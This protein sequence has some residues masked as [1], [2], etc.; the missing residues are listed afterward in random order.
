M[1]LIKKLKDGYNIA[2]I[3]DAGT[4]GISDPGSIMVRNCIKYG[5]NFEIIPGATAVTTALV[6]SGLDTSK[7]IFIGFLPRDVKSKMGILED[8]AERR[9]TLIFYEAPH[10][11]LNTLKQMRTA[12]G[13]RYAAVC[14]EL[15]K[16]HEEILRSTL[17]EI[18]NYYENREIRGEFVIVVKGK[19]EEEFMREKR[20][21]WINLSIEEHIKMYMDVGL[22]KKESVKKVAKDRNVS[23][24]DIYIHSI[25]LQ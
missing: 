5:M 8:M 14:R 15:T 24:S 12:L 16:I 11:L 23:K 22:S 18:L 6:Y 9:E 4:P 20:Q 13:N 19:S 10:R 1:E 2:L 3:S 25:N 21:K 17:E 7:F